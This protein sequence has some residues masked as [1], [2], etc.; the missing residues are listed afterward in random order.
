MVGQR[1]QAPP[2]A[3]AQ[4]IAAAWTETAATGRVLQEDRDAEIAF[5]PKTGKEIADVKN[6]RT[7]CIAQPHWQ[8][9]GKSIS[10]LCQQLERSQANANLARFLEK[11]REMQ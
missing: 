1:E 6:W 11:A 4:V 7:V 2:S 10:F 9:S 5:L 8:G 3:C